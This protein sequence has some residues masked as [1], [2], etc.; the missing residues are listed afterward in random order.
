MRVRSG[1]SAAPPDT[2]HGNRGPRAR[3]R[4]PARGTPTPCPAPEHS[5]KSASTPR[6]SCKVGAAAGG[7]MTAATICQS[8]IAAAS[9]AVADAIC[10]GSRRVMA[11]SGGQSHAQRRGHKVG[12]YWTRSRP[13][14]CKGCGPG[15]RD[16][17]D[18]DLG[19]ITNRLPSHDSHGASIMHQR[20][21]PA[22]A[23]E[24]ELTV[25]WPAAGVGCPPSL[26]RLRSRVRHSLQH[27]HRAWTGRARSPEFAAP[28]SR[29]SPTVR[30]RHSVCRSVAP[31]PP[32]TSEHQLQSTASR[33]RR[34]R[35]SG[36]D[37]AAG[38]TGT[39]CRQS[40]AGPAPEARTLSDSGRRAARARP[41][42]GQSP[43]RA[44]LGAEAADVMER[45]QGEGCSSLRKAH[46]YNRGEDPL[47]PRA[48]RRAG[49]GAASLPEAV[50]PLI[51][52]WAGMAGQDVAAHQLSGARF[53]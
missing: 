13:R 40:L 36:A 2:F 34:P 3:R 52:M 8:V 17:R 28:A 35:R 45:L 4:R 32:P 41:E 30:A 33:A 9:A 23:T 37:C 25:L 48:L 49:R 19:V 46:Q 38:L 1:R 50:L 12:A 44:S 22:A 16:G 5:H 11:A 47:S 14:K 42:P 6:P 21:P 7:E 20:G 31:A 10:D 27:K 29:L 39:H 24:I 53:P 43:A 15:L 51:G 18:D 26:C